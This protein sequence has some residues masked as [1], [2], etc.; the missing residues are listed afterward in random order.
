MLH[1]LPG[2]LL[3]LPLFAIYVI[4]VAY[5]SSRP[6]RKAPSVRRFDDDQL[7]A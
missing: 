2:I 7:A 3:M 5:L 6:K 4:A 1:G